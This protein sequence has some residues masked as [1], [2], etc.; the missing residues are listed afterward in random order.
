MYRKTFISE[1]I[2]VDCGQASPIPRQK[3]RLR[4]QNHVKD[5]YCPFCKKDTKH[6]EKKENGWDRENNKVNLE[7]LYTEK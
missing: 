3:G 7:D 4:K 2:C 1:M 5:M 6:V